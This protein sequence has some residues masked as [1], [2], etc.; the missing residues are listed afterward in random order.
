MNKIHLFRLG[1]T[2]E[3]YINRAYSEFHSPKETALFTQKVDKAFITGKSV[4]Y[5]YKSFRDDK[6]FLQTLSPV[7]NFNNETTAITIIS[8]DITM[9]K[10]A[11]EKLYSMS[12]T[13]ELTGLYNRRGLL[14]LSDQQFKL[15]NRENKKMFLMSAD[16]DHLKLINDHLGHK[17]GDRALINTANI[18]K[19]SFRES[20][21]IARMG[22]DEFVALGMVTPYSG[23]E[24]LTERL[25]ENLKIHNELADVPLED[26]SLSFGFAVYD[27]SHPCSIDELL[28]NADKLM[29][30]EK[31]VKK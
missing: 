3:Q 12:I 10:H 27:P 1:L 4:Q 26:I 17:T 14:T 16:I 18:L 2:E 29:Y 19:E 11:E 13:D 7:K 22:G 28:T 21:I 20:D 5:D 23:I 8:K 15:A 31:H 6:Y 25:N 9:L 24:T 30:E